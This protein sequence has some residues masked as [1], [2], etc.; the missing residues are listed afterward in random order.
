[1]QTSR[2]DKL[3]QG[4]RLAFVLGLLLLFLLG[5]GRTLLRPAEINYFEN[6]PAERLA[7]LTAAGF[8]D[9]S[10]Q[11]SLEAALSD[12]VP[13]ALRLKSAYNE[14]N[15]S[16]LLSVLRRETPGHPEL[17][18]RINDVYIHADRA[19][20]EPFDPEPLMPQIQ[21]TAEGFNRA[22][23]ENPELD[24]YFYF[25]ESDAVLDFRTGEK[26][27]FYELLCSLLALPEDHCARFELR[28]YE[29]FCRDFFKTD[30]HWNHIGA[31]EGYTQI[32]GLLGCAEAP[33]EPLEELTLPGEICGSKAQ[34]AGL[35]ELTEP[36]TAY[37]FAYPPLGTDF[38]HEEAFFAGNCALELNYGNFYG[39]DDGLVVF[40]TGREERPNLLVIGD[41]YDNAVLKLIA[42]HFHRTYAVDLRNYAREQGED[43][44]LG[45]FCREHEVDQV[46]IL[47]S[48]VVFCGDYIV[49]D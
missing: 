36:F 22:M 40:D 25:V 37:R 14:L 9:G 24:F 41:S 38:G 18:Y 43:F 19:L 7:P 32:L 5:L 20:W 15:S 39:G 3:L 34:Q 45:A 33:L 13:G 23:A 4:C 12:Q 48:Q 17:F 1:M 31:Y 16:L 42:C 11:D 27:P 44:H 30:H 47:A 8:L 46:L 49:E 29:Q 26:T 21:A 6:R 2:N 35:P 28:D 10:F